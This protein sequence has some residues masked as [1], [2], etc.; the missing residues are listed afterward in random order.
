MPFF[1]QSSREH[2][3][4]EVL[5]SFL[6]LT[7]YLVKL[8]AGGTLLKHL[9]DHILFNPGL[10]IYASVE[11]RNDLVAFQFLI[12]HHYHPPPVFIEIFMFPTGND[13]TV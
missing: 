2:I 3:T 8:P 9:F 1:F 6:K 13:C 10:W 12:G 7:Q 5:N 11:V 4:P